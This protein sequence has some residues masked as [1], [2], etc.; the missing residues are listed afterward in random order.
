MNLHVSTHPL[1]RHKIRLLADE[2]TDAKLFRELVSELTTLLLYEATT[3]LPVRPVAY[4]TPLEATEGE[5]IAVRI[6]LVP[7]LR[8][9]LGMEEAALTAL[10]GSQVWHLGLYRDETTHRPVSYY[11]RLPETCPDDLVILL[12][13]MLATGGSAAAAAQTLVEWGAPRI[14]YVGMIAAPEG[15]EL[16]RRE[17]PDVAIHVARLD[18]QLDAN[19]FIRPG[20]GDAGDRMFGTVPEEHASE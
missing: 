15:V 11:N 17:H 14:I 18:R 3:D 5:E 9:G 12:D 2:R 20:L 8:A 1:V 10:P 4:Q 6:G 19:A 13:P 16:M 7:V